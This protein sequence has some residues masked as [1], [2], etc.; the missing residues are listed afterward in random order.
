LFPQHGP[1]PK[2]LRAIVLDPWQT[3]V[4]VE[5]H[6]RLLLR[7]LIHSDGCRY[8]NRIRGRYE[9]PSYSFSNRSADIRAI[10]MLTC[11]RLEISYR[12]TYEWTISIAK[13]KDVA[14]LDVFI[15]P[16]C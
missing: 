6:P 15:G 5:R 13:R 1:G 12:Q 3:W 8:I 4:A 14:K 10:F 7:G 9:Y 16:K 11:D 2:H